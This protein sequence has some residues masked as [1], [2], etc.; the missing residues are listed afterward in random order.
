MLTLKNRSVQA[1]IVLILVWLGVFLTSYAQNQLS[2]MSVAFM[3]QYGF[4]PE[5]YAAIYTSSQFVGMFFAI[6]V[7]PISDKIGTRR[8][9]LIAGILAVIGLFARIFAFSFEMQYASNVLCGFTGLFLAVNRAKVLGGWF[10]PAT[11]AIAVGVCTTTTPVANT[12]GVGLT[13]LMPSVTVAFVVS[14]VISAAFFLG[15]LF[16]G[17]ERSEDIALAEKTDALPAKSLWAYF[18]D[19]AKT[20]WVWVLGAGAFCVMG[21]NVPLMAFTNASL[22]NARGLDPVAAGGFATAITIAM[23][24]GSV[25]TP[26][27]VKLIKAYRPV[28]IAYGV[29]GAA[30]VFFGW[31]MP[32]GPLMYGVYFIAGWSIGSLMAMVFTWPVLIYGRDSAATAGGIVQVF[33]LAGASIV[34]TQII[35]P[36]MGGANYMGIFGAATVALVVGA[37]FM[38][39]IPDQGKKIAGAKA[40]DKE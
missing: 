20:P 40:A 28:V 8:I 13:S 4:T 10:P 17:K 29:L 1:V 24:V 16:F 18:R 9:I 14:A 2:G 38:L 12:F 39:V 7:G 34:L 36:I 35:L 11:I 26:F 37:I 30:S 23:G 33:V 27:L 25:V 19:V 21:A 32:I 5:Q 3:A 6:F 31:Q 15:W 22:I